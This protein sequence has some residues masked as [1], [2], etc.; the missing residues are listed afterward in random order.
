[1]DDCLQH[2]C[3]V[4]T[5]QELSEH[6]DDQTVECLSCGWKGS[7]KQLITEQACPDGTWMIEGEMCDVCPKCKSVSWEVID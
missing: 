1:M 4:I 6:Y 2:N 3:G 5:T 7:S